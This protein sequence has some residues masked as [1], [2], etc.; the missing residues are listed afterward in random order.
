MRSNI[1]QPHRKK[2]LDNAITLS[3]HSNVNTD[4][5]TYNG[6]NVNSSQD[7]GYD[8]KNKWFFLTALTLDTHFISNI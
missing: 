4:V 1:F 3:I 6:R 2:S 5:N 8:K 7:Q